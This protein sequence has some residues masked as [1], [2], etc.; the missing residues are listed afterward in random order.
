[1]KPASQ[2]QNVLDGRPYPQHPAILEADAS[3]RPLEKAYLLELNGLRVPARYD[4]DMFNDWQHWGNHYYFFEVPSRWFACWQVALGLISG[5]R[6]GLVRP[7]A[8]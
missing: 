6:G 4:C 2:V 8:L 3:M 7:R 1:M 5:L